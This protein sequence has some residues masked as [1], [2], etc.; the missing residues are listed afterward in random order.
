MPFRLAGVLAIVALALSGPARAG[1]APKVAVSIKPIHALVAGVMA[2]V[3]EPAL[4]VP[5]AASPHHHA[6][7]PSEAKALHEA[8]LVFWIGRE[9][10]TF[11][12]RALGTLAKETRVVALGEAAGVERLGLRAGDMAAEGDV[13]Q[14]HAA[15]DM[16][17]WLDPDNARAMTRAIVR[18]LTTL[19]AANAVAYAANGAAIERRIG[20]LDRRLARVLG[21]LK[22][23][24]YVVFHDAYQYLERRYG[25]RP[26]ASVTVHPDRRPGARTIR[27]VREA[28][29]KGGALC[30]FIQPQ[31]RPAVVETLVAGTGARIGRLDPMGA[32]VPPGPGAYFTLMGELAAALT[33]CLARGE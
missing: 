30:V 3:G 32:A 9:L 28:I 20:A 18:N 2:G 15:A 14:E 33:G 12:E 19:D 13:G 16:H 25:L 17:L 27:R 10:E 31:F 26:L 1:K 29:L 8:R 23:R 6:I 22:D 4:L 21:P 7:R 11:L 24:P 5:G